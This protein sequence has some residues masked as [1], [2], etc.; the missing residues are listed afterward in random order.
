M[1]LMPMLQ[2]SIIGIFGHP[3]KLK[4]SVSSN[5]RRNS[6]LD[7]PRIILLAIA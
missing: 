4:Q 1:F 6:S 2:Q 5:A 7:K 3:P